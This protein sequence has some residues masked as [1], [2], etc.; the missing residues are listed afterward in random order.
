MNFKEVGCRLDQLAQV[1]SN[2]GLVW[3]W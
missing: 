3:S 1:K 2:G